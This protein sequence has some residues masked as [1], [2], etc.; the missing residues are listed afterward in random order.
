MELP[1]D[2]LSNPEFIKRTPLTTAEKKYLKSVIRQKLKIKDGRPT[3][4]AKNSPAYKLYDLLLSILK[5]PSQKNRQRRLR[6]LDLSLKV[7]N[8]EG[9]YKELTADLY[10][11]KNLL[12]TPVDKNRIFEKRKYQN[13]RKYDERIRKRIA[14]L[15]PT[16]TKMKGK[17]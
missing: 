1:I 9:S 4:E 14:D 16:D 7:L 8:R 15:T 5:H 11:I 12:E 17:K 6:S 2:F 10:E 3:K 13:L